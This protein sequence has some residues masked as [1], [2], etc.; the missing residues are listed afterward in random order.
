MEHPTP[1][2]PPT[3]LVSRASALAIVG[4]AL[5]IVAALLPW[6]ATATA[7]FSG[8]D[9]GDGFVTFGVGVAVGIVAIGTRSNR[10]I[11][12]LAG[13]GGCL[14]LVVAARWYRGILAESVSDPAVGLLLTVLAG[15][16]LVASAVVGLVGGLS[17]GRQT[18]RDSIEDAGT[19]DR[20]AGEPND[21]GVE[22]NES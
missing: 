18:G 4:C 13:I 6:S 19:E 10:T 2:E 5:L 14:A 3:S 11:G 20:R 8:L 7:T 15:L 9:H 21:D 17:S 16:T 12:L 22:P 1:T